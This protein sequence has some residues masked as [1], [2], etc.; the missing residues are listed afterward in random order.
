[1][2]FS[3]KPV[4]VV[5][6]HSLAFYVSLNCCLKHNL[7]FLNIHCLLLNI[8]TSERTKIPLKKRNVVFNYLCYA[9]LKPNKQIKEVSLKQFSLTYHSIFP[10][11]LELKEFNSSCE[12]LK[13][14]LARSYKYS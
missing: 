7:F 6:T 1:M 14:L 4:F 2:K 10:N 12:R 8:A 3:I 5:H 13:S 11:V 9:V